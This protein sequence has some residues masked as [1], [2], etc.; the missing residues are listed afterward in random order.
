MRRLRARADLRKTAGLTFCR[1]FAGLVRM[2]SGYCRSLTL[3]GV[4]LTWGLMT[5]LNLGSASGSCGHYVFTSAEWAAHQ[6]LTDNYP[7]GLR[8]LSHNHLFTSHHRPLFKSHHR[9]LVQSDR[10]PGDDNAPCHGPSCRGGGFPMNVVASQLP[11]VDKE[12]LDI[13]L[14]G[15]QS[16]YANTGREYPCCSQ[17]S[18][19]EHFAQLLRPPRA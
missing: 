17:F 16:E 6:R 1:D 19:Q 15:Y 14:V 11:V 12:Q 4:L 18:S 10:R 13:V 9:F 5:Q 8:G 3:L 7:A 2:C